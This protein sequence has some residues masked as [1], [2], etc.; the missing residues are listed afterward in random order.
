[1]RGLSGMCPNLIGKVK[2]DLTVV[3]R[4][5]RGEFDTNHTVVTTASTCCGLIVTAPAAPSLTLTIVTV[6][7]PA[8]RVPG[9]CSVI[10]DN[11]Y[12]L[13]LITHNSR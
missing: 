5:Q 8:G 3:H 4:T 1:M 6:A 9:G 2:T 10:T 7:V 13:C 11:F 12:I